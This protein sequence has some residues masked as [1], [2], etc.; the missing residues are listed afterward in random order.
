[1]HENFKFS[2]QCLLFSIFFPGSSKKSKLPS[3]EDEINELLMIEADIANDNSGG[4]ETTIVP[5]GSY[6]SN[7][8]EG[9]FV[10]I[11]WF[12]CR[13]HLL[14][15]VVLKY[16]SEHELYFYSGRKNGN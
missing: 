14:L 8:C 4:Y 15:I 2:F 6:A 11:V 5:A 9:F 10:V 3:L 13:K 1:M 12:I 16:F 7:N